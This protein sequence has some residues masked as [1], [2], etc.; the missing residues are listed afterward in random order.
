MPSHYQ[1]AIHDIDP[2]VNPAG[3]EAH[4]RLQYF[5]LDHLDASAFRTE[6]ALAKLTE[7]RHPGYLRE[8][9]ESH[10][11]THDYNH[12]QPLLSEPPPDPECAVCDNPGPRS[13]AMP[14]VTIKELLPALSEKVPKA[15]GDAGSTT[16]S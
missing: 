14:D 15:V 7:H 8:A 4:M 3:V 16:R 12:W 11:M 6:T 1:K 10:A 9:A 2:T 5:T 13:D